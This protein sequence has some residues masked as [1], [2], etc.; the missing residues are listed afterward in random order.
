MTDEDK[1]H[2]LPRLHISQATRMFGMTARAVRYYE[3]RGLIEACRDEHNRR[4]YDAAARRR[5]RWIGELR[6]AGLSLRD[7]QD[8]LDADEEHAGAG[9]D[10]ALERLE[11]RRASLRAEVAKI[12]DLI[13][14]LSERAAPALQ[15][16]R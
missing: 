7:I 12:D 13:G 3:E 2:F 15:Q 14:G 10:I 1:I 11:A 16:A 4:L 9:D 5:L 8:V 6:S